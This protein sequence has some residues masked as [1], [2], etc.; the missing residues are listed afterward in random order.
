MLRSQIILALAIGLLAVHP[1]E[2]QKP[3]LDLSRSAFEAK[4][5]GQFHLAIGL[6]DRAL[7]ESDLT[8]AQR[9][10]L[11]YGRGASYQQLDARGR[12]LSDLDAAI[13]LLPEFPN[14]YV[15]RALVWNSERRYEEAIE[16]L[17][18]AQK[19]A[20]KDPTVLMNLAGA[21]A[22]I[23]QLDRAIETYDQAI[24]ER[25]DAAQLYYNRAVT[26]ILRKDRAKALTD[27]N[28]AI[29]LRPDFADAYENRGVLL[30]VEGKSEEALSDFNTAINLAPSDVKFRENRA[31]ALLAIGRRDEALKEFEFALKI[32]PG[33]PALYMGRGKTRLF[34]ENF[35]ASV[36]DLKSAVRLRPL[37]PYAVIWL[38]IARLHADVNDDREFAEN[39]ARISRGAWPGAAIDLYLGTSSAEQM[40]SAVQATKDDTGRHGCEADFFVG[41][42]EGHLGNAETS[43][44]MLERVVSKCRA[45]DSVYSAAKAELQRAAR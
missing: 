37:N 13:A 7:Q 6:F 43:K 26:Y 33:N 21:L 2:A 42:Y 31:Y 18:F 17:H 11:Y 38:H 4:M 5:Q 10:M 3:A 19:R 45:F 1:A 24:K 34:L 41:D 8:T 44:E 30:S 9:G 29:A 25:P 14:S 23:G 40:A 27:L 20:P 35:D 28:Q 15:Y 16:D 39:A 12:A 32:D 22:Q 36:E